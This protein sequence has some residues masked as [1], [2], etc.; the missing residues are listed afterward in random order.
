MQ[1]RFVFLVTGRELAGGVPSGAIVTAVVCAESEARV[2]RLVEQNWPSFQL[3]TVTGL[4]ALE[5]RAQ[6]I[7]DT[8]GG[9]VPEWS[10]L[11]DPELVPR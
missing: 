8:L 4:A 7:K 6:K 10:V 3:T 11:V 9:K 1:K 2:K 5:A